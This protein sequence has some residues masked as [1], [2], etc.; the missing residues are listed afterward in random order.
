MGLSPFAC[1][2]LLPFIGLVSCLTAVSV[3]ADVRI[4]EHGTMS[5]QSKQSS[6]K[7]AWTKTIEIKGQR[8]RLESGEGAESRGTIY[9]LDSGKRFRLAPSSKEVLVLDLGAGQHSVEETGPGGTV[10]EAGSS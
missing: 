10:I 6:E 4:T 5:L 9:D 3:S 2:S 1:H 7:R 8:M